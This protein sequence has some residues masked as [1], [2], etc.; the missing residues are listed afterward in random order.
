MNEREKIWLD[1]GLLGALEMMDASCTMAERLNEEHIG[2]PI[3]M[4]QL[5]ETIAAEIVG[6]RE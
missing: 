6:K 1:L 2:N 3:A 5:M 4:R